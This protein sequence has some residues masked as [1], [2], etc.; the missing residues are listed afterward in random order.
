MLFFYSILSLYTII[1]SGFPKNSLI[2]NKYINR[3]LLIM[4]F[5]LLTVG[6]L[7]IKLTDFTDLFTY[8]RKFQSMQNT[9]F[10][11]TSTDPL[12]AFLMWI[13]SNLFDSFELFII[14]IW[15]I[16]F[17]NYT[18]AVNLLFDNNESLFVIFSYLNFFLFFNYILNVIRQGMAISFLILALASLVN[19]KHKK[20]YEFY[21]YILVAPLFHNTA[22]YG[23]VILLMLKHINIRLKTVIKI[24]LI[25]V[26]LFLTNF[27]RIF[28]LLPIDYYSLYTSDSIIQHYGETNRLDFL[29]FSIIFGIIGIYLYYKVTKKIEYEIIVKY[30]LLMNILFLALGFISFSDRLAGYSWLIIPLILWKGFEKSSQ[31]RIIAF[32]LLII[33]IVSGII[34]GVSEDILSI[35]VIN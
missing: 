12:F 30:Y 32:L 20:N 5:G 14:L 34:M 15:G 24:W 6:I 4:F 33:F 29:I 11:I 9:Q 18:K 7:N 35:L 13:A 2:N 17:L 21:L 28:L 3:L 26:V 10:E 31:Y 8:N 19:G 25:F 16:V 23:S 1:I 27:N 22:I